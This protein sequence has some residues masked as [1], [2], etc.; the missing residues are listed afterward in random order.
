M[1]ADEDGEPALTGARLAQVNNFDLELAPSVVLV[2]DQ[3]LVPPRATKRHHRVR[4]HP[5]RRVGSLARSVDIVVAAGPGAPVAAITVEF[6]AAMGVR[7]IVTVGQAGLLNTNERSANDPP[8]NDRSPDDRSPCDLYVISRAESDE[9]TSLYYSKNLAADAGLTSKLSATLGGCLGVTLT[10]DVPFRH[11][12]ARL[13]SHRARADLV[14]MECA[15]VFSAAQHFGL[16]AGAVLVTS[17]VFGDTGWRQ[18]EPATVKRS[19]QYAVQKASTVLA[20]PL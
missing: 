10:T 20:H 4:T 13:G 2:Y 17:D 16:A 12:P 15:A 7:R 9:G 8:A 1:V 11:T 3:S 14:E 5:F 18:L 19:L 6:L